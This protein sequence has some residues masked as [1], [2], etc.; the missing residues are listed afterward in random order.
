MLNCLE[1]YNFLKERNKFFKFY[2]FLLLHSSRDWR[3]R[4]SIK[5][6]VFS[7]H[8]NKIKTRWFISCF[9]H[10]K[11]KW[12][13]FFNQIDKSVLFHL[14]Q[15]W[16]SSTTLLELLMGSQPWFYC[17][18][19]AHCQHCHQGK[20]LHLLFLSLFCIFCKISRIWK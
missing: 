11:V 9:Q 13:F 18:R 5:V 3:N 20:F 17:L 16:Q 7:F 14:K 4:N 2:S 6:T 10:G 12:M 19:S 8:K 1:D 15:L